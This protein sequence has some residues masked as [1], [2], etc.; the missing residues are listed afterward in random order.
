VCGQVRPRVIAVSCPVQGKRTRDER[1]GA[2]SLLLRALATEARR[3]PEHTLSGVG[4]ST[5]GTSGAA[6]RAP[7]RGG[8]R[9]AALHGEGFAKAWPSQATLWMALLSGHIFGEG[10]SSLRRKQ[11]CDRR[12]PSQSGWGKSSRAS[13]RCGERLSRGSP[14]WPLA[15]EISA[16]L[17]PKGALATR[18]KSCAGGDSGVVCGARSIKRLCS[19]FVSIADVGKRRAVLTTTGE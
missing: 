9:E 1:K 7:L 4:S 5:E 8:T 3:G 10:D 19:Q 18:Y 2:G 13:D 17:A 15:R 14:R 6:D 11:V 12:C 16:G